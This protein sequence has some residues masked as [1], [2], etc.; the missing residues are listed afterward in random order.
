MGKNEIPSY[1]DLT[2]EEREYFDIADRIADEEGVDRGLVKSV[3]WQE[4]GL[5]DEKIGRKRLRR[6]ALSPAGARGLMQ[7]MPATGDELGLKDPWDPEDN[8]RAGVRYLKQN[9]KRFGGDVDKTIASYNAGPGNA[10]RWQRI[11]ETSKYV[12]LVKGYWKGLRRSDGSPASP[13]AATREPEAPEAPNPALR[14]VPLAGGKPPAAPP[15]L[16]RAQ[17]REPLPPTKAIDVDPRATFQSRPLRTAGDLDVRGTMR[18]P[19]SRDGV[20]ASRPSPPAVAPL[21]N[22]SVPAP[23]EAIGVDEYGSGAGTEAPILGVDMPEIARESTALGLRRSRVGRPASLGPPPGPR[24]PKLAPLPKIDQVERDP[25]G[26]Y[27]VEIYDPVSKE[28]KLYEGISEASALQI[29]QTGRA[30][31]AEV[32]R[33][34]REATAHNASPYTLTVPGKKGEEAKVYD[35]LNKAEAVSLGGELLPPSPVARRKVLR[36]ARPGVAPAAG[37]VDFSGARGGFTDSDGVKSGISARGKAAP[38][39]TGEGA[40]TLGARSQMETRPTAG[41][42]RLYRTPR[43]QQEFEENQADFR[44]RQMMAEGHRIK[45]ALRRAGQ[46]ASR[47]VDATGKIGPYR[48]DEVTPS[49]LPS[50]DDIA[51]PVARTLDEALRGADQAVLDHLHQYK[52][53]PTSSARRADVLPYNER[54]G[55]KIVNGAVAAVRGGTWA[56]ASLANLPVSLLEASGATRFFPEH[57]R[58]QIEAQ[59]AIEGWSSRPGISIDPRLDQAFEALSE[60]EKA[61]TVEM[62]DLQGSVMWLTGLAVTALATGGL[63]PASAGTSAKLFPQMWQ[64]FKGG[65]KFGAATSALQYTYDPTASISSNV[66]HATEHVL[67]GAATGAAFGVALPVIAKSATEL[68]R[69]LKRIQAHPGGP[70]GGDPLTIKKLYETEFADQ[71]GPGLHDYDALRGHLAK[72]AIDDWV[73]YWDNWKPDSEFTPE[74]WTEGEWQRLYE[75][76]FWMK[77]TRPELLRQFDEMLAEEAARNPLGTELSQRSLEAGSLMEVA[78]GRRPLGG[79]DDVAETIESGGSA[80]LQTSTPRPPETIAGPGTGTTQL[81]RARQREIEA[82]PPRP[83]SLGGDED[84]VGE[85]LARR[86]MQQRTGPEAPLPELPPVTETAPVRE[87]EAVSTPGAVAQ[88]AGNAPP[89]PRATAPGIYDAVGIRFDVDETGRV[90]AELTSAEPDER[91][92]ARNALIQ[93]GFIKQD[94]TGSK[95]VAPENRRAGA[96]RMIEARAVRREADDAEG[97]SGRLPRVSGGGG[98]TEVRPGDEALSTDRAS[99]GT[100]PLVSGEADLAP[101]EQPARPDTSEEPPAE[102]ARPESD[103]APIHKYS[104]T[105]VE[106]PREIQEAH[107]ALQSKFAEE[108]LAGDGLDVGQGAEGGAHVTVRYGI[109]ADDP[110]SLRA[111]LERFAPVTV[112]LGETKSFEPGEHSDGA[113][114]IYAEATSDALIA[115]NKAIEESGAPLKKNDFEYK[116]HMTIGYVR[117]EAAGKY[118]GLTDL[119]GKTFTVKEIVFRD[120]TGK[121]H[122]VELKGTGEASEGVDLGVSTEGEAPNLDDRRKADNDIVRY[123]AENGRMTSDVLRAGNFEDAAERILNTIQTLASSEAQK[124]TKLGNLRAIKQ[125]QSAPD[126][127]NIPKDLADKISARIDEAIR[128]VENSEDFPHDKSNKYYERRNDPQAR[129]H[130]PQKQTFDDEGITRENVA[131]RLG[132]DSAHPLI[133]AFAGALRAHPDSI[134]FEGERADGVNKHYG[135]SRF[136]L[137]TKKYRVVFQLHDYKDGSRKFIVNEILKKVKDKKTGQIRLDPAQTFKDQEAFLK[138]FAAENPVKEASDGQETPGGAGQTG[139]GPESDSVEGTRE[140]S[141][142]GDNRASGRLPESEDGAVDELDG[143]TAAEN[144]GDGEDATR[145]AAE[146]L[147]GSGRSG[148]LPKSEPSVDRGSEDAEGDDTTRA[149]QREADD[150][151]VDDAS[152]ESVLG[153]PVP[154][155]QSGAPD[156]RV[157]P[158]HLMGVAVDLEEGFDKSEEGVSLE[159]YTSA[160]EGDTR[161]FLLLTDTDAGKVVDLSSYPTRVKG[162]GALSKALQVFGRQGAK[163][164]RRAGPKSQESSDAIIGTDSEREDSRGAEEV[165]TVRGDGEGTSAE[166]P[167]VETGGTDEGGDARVVSEGDRGAS[168]SGGRVGTLAGEAGGEV[169]ESG[170]SGGSERSGEGTGVP[171]TGAG[172]DDARGRTKTPRSQNWRVTPEHEQWLET[173][174]KKTKFRANID[175]IKL[176]Q[177]LTAENRAPTADEQATL[178]RY[179]G[180]GQFPQAFEIPWFRKDQNPELY[181]RLQAEAEEEGVHQWHQVEAKWKDERAELAELLGGVDSDVYKAARAST[182]NAHYTSP[183]VIRSMYEALARFGFT[184]GRILEPALGTGNFLAN[185]P[186]SVAKSKDT[187]ITGVELDPLTAEIARL[188]YPRDAERIYQ[189]G[190]QSAPIPNNYYDVAISNVPFGD[191]QIYDGDINKE[192]KVGGSGLRVHNYFFAKALEKVRP[193]G[194][195]AFVTSTGTMDAKTA[196]TFR[197]QIADRANLLGAIRLPGSAFK[198]AAGTEV[199]TDVIFLQKLVPGEEPDAQS[200][201]KVR[202]QT[203]EGQSFSVNEYFVEHPEMIVGSLVPDKLHPQRAGVVLKDPGK[204]EDRIK[205]AIRRLPENV[206]RAGLGARAEAEPVTLSAFT[207]VGEVKEGNYHVRGGKVYRYG[208]GEF[209]EVELPK[210]VDHKRVQGLIGLRDAVRTVLK[211]QITDAPDEEQEKARKAL[212]KA[213]NAFSKE[214]GTV[215]GKDRTNRQALRGDPDLELL[216]ALE[217]FTP[218]GKVQKSDIF[219]KRVVASYAPVERAETAADA[220]RVSIGEL[221]RIDFDRI[222]A[223][224]ETSALGAEQE[225]VA[226]GLIFKD[227]ETQRWVEREEYLSGPVRRKLKAARNAEREMP[228]TKRNV[229][230]LEAVQP[231]DIP[232]NEIRI[233]LASPFIREQDVREFLFHILNVRYI[234][235][236]IT[237][238]GTGFQIQFTK[239]D[240]ETLKDLNSN[241][242]VWGTER[243]PALNLI[244][245]GLNQRGILVKDRI[246]GGPPPKYAVNETATQLAR[247]RMQKIEDEFAR[248]LWDDEARAQYYHTYYNETYN[249]QAAREWDSTPYAIPGLTPEWAEKMH[250]HQWAAIRRISRGRNTLLAHVVG[251]GKTVEMAAGA[252]EL[253]RLGLAKKPMIAVP[254]HMLEQWRN[255]VREAFPDAKLLVADEESISAERRRE[256]VAR[257]ATGDFDLIIM[258][259]S[260]MELVPLSNKTQR[261]MIDEQIRELEHEIQQARL[262]QPDTKRGVR[263]IKSLESSRNKLVAKLEEMADATSDTGATFEQ[264]GVDQIFVDEIHEFKNLFLHT[265]LGNIAGIPKKPSDKSFDLFQKTRYI[266]RKRGEGR[267]VVGATGTPVTNTLAEVFTM[268]RFFQWKELERRGLTRFDSWAA[269]HARAVRDWEFSA[270]G[271]Y[272][273]VTRFSRFVNMPELQSLFRQSADVKLVE[274]LPYLKRP[275]LKGGKVRVVAGEASPAYLEYIKDLGARAEAVRLGEVE[276]E[277]D[278]MLRINGDG[279]KASLDMRLVGLGGDTAHASGKIALAVEEIARIWEETKSVKGTQLVFSDLGTPKP[280]QEKKG[281][282]KK[283]LTPEEEM[284]AAIDA[285]LAADGINFSVYGEVKDLLVAK[286]IPAAEIAFIHDYESATEK[287]ALF[288]AVNAGKIRILLGSTQKMGAGTNV[289]KKLV[290]LHH[291]DAPW[292]PADVEQRDGRGLRQGNELYDAGAIDGIEIVRYITKGVNEQSSFDAYIW[293]LLESKDRFIRDFMKGRGGRET[294]DTGESLLNAAELS[295]LATGNPMVIER[296]KLMKEISHLEL[297]RR[298]HEQDLQDYRN[299]MFLTGSQIA[300]LEKMTAAT[301][302]ILDSLR[303]R[304]QSKTEK[305]ERL[306]PKEP[307]DVGTGE[308]KDWGEAGVALEKATRAR[309]S[310]LGELARGLEKADKAETDR[311][312]AEINRLQDEMVGGFGNVGI[313]IKVRNGFVYAIHSPE[314]D[315][316]RWISLA[317]IQEAKVEGKNLF[318]HVLD[319]YLSM[320]AGDLKSNTDHLGRLRKRQ[321]DLKKQNVARFRGQEDLD[322]KR[323]RLT[324]IEIEMGFHEDAAGTGDD[325]DAGLASLPFDDQLEYVPSSEIFFR[326]PKTIEADADTLEAFNADIFHEFEPGTFLYPGFGG[327]A[328]ELNVTGKDVA[329]LHGAIGKGVL[330]LTVDKKGARALVR[331]LLGAK[332]L[333]A[334]SYASYLQAFVESN[335]HELVIL[336]PS[337]SLYEKGTF[338]DDVSRHEQFHATQMR[339]NRL[340]F[341]EMNLNE[342][343]DVGDLASVRHADKVAEHLRA[344][345]YTDTPGVMLAEAMAHV[346][347]DPDVTKLG[348]TETEAEEFMAD[349]FDLLAEK[350]GNEAINEFTT[351]S[352]SLAEIQRIQYEALTAARTQAVTARGVGPSQRRNVLQTERSGERAADTVRGPP[353]GETPAGDEGFA[354]LGQKKPPIG[355]HDDDLD[356]II[357]TQKRHQDTL[358]RQ[359]A[360]TSQ[361]NHATRM[362]ES[363]V[364]RYA[365]VYKYLFDDAKRFGI[366]PK[367]SE[368]PVVTIAA[369][370]GVNGVVQ[371]GYIEFS[372]IQRDAKKAKLEHALQEYLNLVGYQRAFVVQKEHARDAIA[373][374]AHLAVDSLPVKFWDWAERKGYVTKDEANRVTTLKSHR[375]ASR[376]ALLKPDELTWE[377]DGA[378]IS[379]LFK[380]H[381]RKE[382]GVF[383]TVPA[384]VQRPSSPNVGKTYS[385]ANT[386]GVTSTRSISIFREATADGVLSSATYLVFAGRKRKLAGEVRA[387][388]RRLRAHTV[389]PKGLNELQVGNKLWRLERALMK[390]G[391]KRDDGSENDYVWTKLKQLGRRVFEQNAIAWDL[392]YQ[393]GVISRKVYEKGKA[394]GPEYVPLE[395]IIVEDEREEKI[396]G[397]RK[398]YLAQQNVLHR[399][400]G[401]SLVNIAPLLTS[402]NRYAETVRESMRNSVGRVFV[403]YFSSNV[404]PLKES[405]EP[406]EGA[407]KL[408]VYIGGERYY[409]AVPEDHA[410]AIGHGLSPAVEKSANLVRRFFEQVSHVFRAGTTGQRLAFSVPNLFRDQKDYY[411]FAEHAPQ[412]FGYERTRRGTP[413]PSVARYAT[414][415]AAAAT[416]VLLQDQQYLRFLR[417]GA[418]GG[419]FQRAFMP[420]V[421][422]GHRLLEHGTAKAY[423]RGKQNFKDVYAELQKNGMTFSALASAGKLVPKTA[424]EVLSAMHNLVFGTIGEFNTMIEETTKL[425]SFTRAYEAVRHQGLS[426]REATVEAMYEA[427][428]YGGS[429]DFGIDGT[430]AQWMRTAFPFVPAATAGSRRT[431]RFLSGRDLYLPGGKGNVVQGGRGS[432]AGPGLPRPFPGSPVGVPEPLLRLKGNNRRLAITAFRLLAGLSFKAISTVLAFEYLVWQFPK[433]NGKGANDLQYDHYTDYERR[434]Y[435][436][437]MLPV[438]VPNAETGETEYF[439]FRVPK[440]HLEQLF[441]NPIQVAVHEALRDVKYGEGE[442]DRVARETFNG[443]AA[444]SPLNLEVDKDSD[445]IQMLGKAGVSASTPAFKV[446]IEQALNQDVFRERP[447]VSREFEAYSPEQQ[448]IAG[449]TSR[450]AQ[451]IAGGIKKTLELFEPADRAT[452]TFWLR[453]PMRVDHV[454]QNVFG[455]FGEQYV[456][457]VD[458]VDDLNENWATTPPEEKFRKAFGAIGAGTVGPLVK[459]MFP[460][461]VDRYDTD[462][463]SEFYRNYDEAETVAADF[464]LIAG[465]QRNVEAAATYTA[466]PR[467]LALLTFHREMDDLLKDLAKTRAAFNHIKGLKVPDAEKQKKLQTLNAEGKLITD[468]LREINELVERGAKDPA[469]IA[470]TPE[471]RLFRYN[472]N[473]DLLKY[474]ALRDYEEDARVQKMAPAERT[475]FLEHMARV[476]DAQKKGPSEVDEI[477]APDVRKRPQ[478]ATS[479]PPRRSLRSFGEESFLDKEIVYWQGNRK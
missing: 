116:P 106:A 397:G 431:V 16:A 26:G 309:V 295:A 217:R 460:S 111:T 130:L 172:E 136:T 210:G 14:E 422:H 282:K 180:W 202:T 438:L 83:R 239:G 350:Y 254:N 479:P 455:G 118:E 68:A 245:A 306:A 82:E 454:I 209:H 193:G 9:G 166:V 32:D 392:A 132:A 298:S 196:A 238:A 279:R 437:G 285:M 159:F 396:F 311:I 75:G 400:E 182:L 384:V 265:R 406:P 337:Y 362:A 466:D 58:A 407:V 242:S 3:M 137:E 112:E 373:S 364:D 208:S 89:S 391:G 236:I 395:R 235:P 323:K 23:V 55:V 10:N 457:L 450:T 420:Q 313:R 259:H 143:R 267:G 200:W 374:A 11:G 67:R 377:D 260:A 435:W 439:T 414:Q 352:E 213:Y 185:I 356:E 273:E 52:G 248:W 344:R 197:R 371:A 436:H 328:P 459:R 29:Q 292:R 224:R 207:D 92:E 302:K 122:V 121:P 59:K 376:R 176:L 475:A 474:M 46:L 310:Q 272:R 187:R 171:A 271:K 97:E 139:V 293:Q 181:E 284:Q 266:E 48:R 73:R 34:N 367:A 22:V 332:G 214:Y 291:L 222:A 312:H 372:R 78:A 317:P 170:V 66:E 297:Q 43:T 453:S 321:E 6:R 296:V 109:E 151:G 256:F 124:K 275:A 304:F 120:R 163:V 91:K 62:L 440:S 211:S 101:P 241:V 232:Q 462:T 175:A 221:G 320:Q 33:Y 169:D 278:N 342:W 326:G 76:T 45:G 198:K 335:K 142:V 442:K 469:S 77:E 470:D 401:S 333:A 451:I 288:Q 410:R 319:R 191:Y 472:R 212:T 201:D 424:V 388:L 398:L 165:R 379:K 381:F 308:F 168:G 144:P 353:K 81:Q 219:T 173:S 402:A 274:D 35:R 405:E 227:P 413:V 394:R 37:P 25:T 199:T 104:T 190:F 8:I 50:V 1:E 113:A 445:A 174:G 61:Q 257:A 287:M 156:A 178:A 129:A 389:V 53:D 307:L 316:E 70:K 38:A 461:N 57:V 108:D 305:G 27:S 463:R 164:T 154:Q 357:E 370:L 403:Q 127:I 117:P 36:R 223:L 84:V 383:P 87:A 382:E 115:I 140:G 41:P 404:T 149:S 255:E 148:L 444:L 476:W 416:H 286:G 125:I 243:R 339:L 145:R 150:L 269:L 268:Q 184:G 358:G 468:R 348:I 102:A 30:N 31:Q 448:K 49:T 93:A 192:W 7:I 443:I 471:A 283:A 387:I 409:F 228:E 253:R 233:R 110:E 331:R 215:G 334:E 167:S 183:A 18:L 160:E 341:D 433:H 95:W 336:F 419:T 15:A 230:A 153:A 427:R 343:A 234:N 426:H 252:M 464:R 186:E 13:A 456:A 322:E 434:A 4:S 2:P 126:Y 107:K 340:F 390:E 98:A 452:K 299:A 247:E 237:K 428:T 338:P 378:L 263:V 399:L 63:G 28:K 425:L 96:A 415:F 264:M 270:E 314:F 429:P 446:P 262:T 195:V 281:K 231:A 351:I 447:I 449:R 380:L 430:M 203:V 162:R 363:L 85:L 290:A 329:V 74:M 155:T 465:K 17:A 386:A 393:E 12:P 123:L 21:E 246:D 134:Q 276:P 418:A 303:T 411:F 366:V 315:D 44:K 189:M 294:E 360:A 64:G 432:G 105:Q 42:D 441:V 458:T 99:G 375:E 229:E 94:R 80:V 355:L 361:L 477:G 138:A 325:D 179:T 90:E 258:T 206:Y 135:K 324:A 141:L 478:R 51:Q 119:K 24:E 19:E 79:M 69:V 5:Y 128:A 467:R 349:A 347:T 250:P 368:N 100:G 158:T 72:E 146:A 218:E 39:P 86:R 345:G 220:L 421:Y 157:T 71:V 65:A 205:E 251:A 40:E 280:K 385:K 114:P 88:D 226:E 369:A 346:A 289:Q 20:T 359:D 131:D 408:P 327:N 194:I 225:L 216:L 60:S 56:V 240:R 300:H 261:E 412:I 177:K 244:E 301:G 249:D 473:L 54:A 133:A 417:S 147:L 47:D 204:L 152:T 161:S 188:L 318:T 365:V 330:G 354:L 103:V 423:R 277:E